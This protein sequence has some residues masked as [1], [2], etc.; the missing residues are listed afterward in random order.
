MVALLCATCEK[1]SVVLD[2]DVPSKREVQL[3][4]FCPTCE[5]V[6]DI[7]VDILAWWQEENPDEEDFYPGNYL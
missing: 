3:R 7:V 1:P 2:F 5:K 6:G 4:L